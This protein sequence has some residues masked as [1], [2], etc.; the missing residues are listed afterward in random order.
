MGYT[1]SAGNRLLWNSNNASVKLLNHETRCS[2]HKRNQQGKDRKRRGQL[3]RNEF[4]TR[5]SPR[6]YDRKPSSK[7]EGVGDTP[8]SRQTEK[9]PQNTS[10]RSISRENLEQ[11][12][13]PSNK[14][15]YKQ[16]RPTAFHQYNAAFTKHK[17]LAARLVTC[18]GNVKILRTQ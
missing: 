13:F 16:K 3:R 11:Q 6:T 4:I 15:L 14:A 1:Y 2:Q 10:F 17:T 9:Q 12:T 18:F 5:E 8:C 7:G